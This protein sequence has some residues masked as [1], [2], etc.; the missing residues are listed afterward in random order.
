MNTISILKSK[1]FIVLSIIMLLYLGLRLWDGNYRIRDSSEYIYSAQQILNGH[2]FGKATNYGDAFRLTLR[3][4][5]YPLFVTIA[6]LM[7]DFS[8]IL[9]QTFIGLLN[10]FLII[11]IYDKLGGQKKWIIV[12][13][14][15]LTP[16]FFI[17]THLIMSEVISLTFVLL[18][19]LLLLYP[20][21]NKNFI[22]IQ[23]LIFC[24]TML[25]PVYYLFPILNLVLF[26]WYFYKRRK[27]NISI[28]LPIILV[29]FYFQFNEYRTGYYHFS[30]IQNK[31]LVHFNIK[32]YKINH[33]GLL[34]ATQWVDSVQQEGEKYADFKTRNEYYNTVA[35]K[36]IREHF[37][38][39]SFYHFYTSLRGVLDPGR[40]DI[41]STF[42]Y[43]ENEQPFS[44]TLLNKHDYKEIFNVLISKYGIILIVLLPIFL[45]NVLKYTC[46]ILYFKKN[47]LNFVTIY[48]IVFCLYNIFLAGPINTSRYMLMI[49]GIVIVYASLYLEKSDILAKWIKK[50]T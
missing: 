13:L 8:L 38:S 35:K 6:L 23:L 40:Y 48:L 5:G 50:Q 26:I 20:F 10:I 34:K 47:K 37:F 4:I 36:E 15:F 19:Q 17:Y 27:F 43:D 9:F 32:Y 49:Q 41:F 25:K 39:Y 31:N 33:D 29:L 1:P 16:S 45:T 14:L 21:S 7:S 11:K 12:G 2:F 30:S 44:L 42:K 46:L 3:T 18:I 22:I 28:F 24:L